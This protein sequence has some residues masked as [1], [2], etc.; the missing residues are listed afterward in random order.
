MIFGKHL[1]IEK[2]EQDPYCANKTPVITA[3]ARSLEEVED[4][5]D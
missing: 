1:N 5:P 3:G 4:I 2:R